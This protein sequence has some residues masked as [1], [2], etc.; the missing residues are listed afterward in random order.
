MW[1][2]DGI[3]MSP[4][5]IFPICVFVCELSFDFCEPSMVIFQVILCLD[6]SFWQWYCKIGTF[7]ESGG[8]FFYTN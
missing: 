5:I 4:V 6:I 2:Y 8:W 7:A 1:S 3:Q